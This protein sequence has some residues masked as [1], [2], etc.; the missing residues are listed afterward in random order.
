VGA[1]GEHKLGFDASTKEAGF[2]DTK[3]APHAFV[4]VGSTGCSVFI[5]PATE[6]IVVFLTNAGFSG[7]SSRRFPALRADIH[8]ALMSL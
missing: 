3:A 6:T 2:I 7:H 8:T 4:A 5:D 1:K